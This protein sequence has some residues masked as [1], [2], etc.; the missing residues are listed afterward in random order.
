M[1]GVW[2]VA[3]YTIETVNKWFF[4]WFFASSTKST[5]VVSLSFSLCVSPVVPLS[6][7]DSSWSTHGR[8][9]EDR[10]L[11]V[12]ISIR[13]CRFYL[14]L[15]LSSIQAWQCWWSLQASWHSP[16][17]KGDIS[18][19]KVSL[20]LESKSSSVNCA[21]SSPGGLKLSKKF[22]LFSILDWLVYIIIWLHIM[23]LTKY[24]IHRLSCRR[25][26]AL[27]VRRWCRSWWDGLYSVSLST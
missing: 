27:M 19:T 11:W 17:T 9:A 13:Y 25:S 21:P 4:S 16:Q 15:P 7:W 24:A 1:S 3:V 12:E 10:D 14:S 20:L 26:L 22:H 18:A 6:L 23:H 5:F 8:A 2:Y